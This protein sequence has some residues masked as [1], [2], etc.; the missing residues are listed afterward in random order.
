MAVLASPLARLAIILKYFSSIFITLL[1]LFVLWP[2]VSFAVTAKDKYYQ[3]EACYKKLRHNPKQQKYRDKW[4]RC[5]KKFKAVYEQDPKGSWAA[6]GLYMSGQLYQ[7][8][9]ERSFKTSDQEAAAD[10][11]ERIIT[12]FPKSK[13]KQKAEY[14]LRH[15]SYKKTPPPK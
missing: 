1:M 6:A 5:I 4:L 11:Y 8:L 12:D 13:Y 7:K 10:I 15:I 14:A 2:Q 9:Y 3:A